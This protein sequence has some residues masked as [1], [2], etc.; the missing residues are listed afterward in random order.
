MCHTTKIKKNMFAAWGAFIV[1]GG[2]SG[3]EGCYLAALTKPSPA[4]RNEH[5][6]LYRA[7]NHLGFFSLGYA[8]TGSEHYVFGFVI[9][10]E[11]KYGIRAVLA[12]HYMELK[13]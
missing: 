3:R 10:D 6:L 9:L 11:F 7:G 4:S 12:I 8:A 5:L 2:E 13:R 1:L